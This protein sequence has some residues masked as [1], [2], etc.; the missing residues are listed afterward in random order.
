[1]EIIHIHNFLITNFY[2]NLHDYLFARNK[3]LIITKEKE[4]YYI[5][6]YHDSHFKYGVPEIFTGIYFFQTIEKKTLAKGWSKIPGN[7][8]Y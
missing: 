1:M 4:L 8:L 6:N 5:I 3:L 2:E 7:L